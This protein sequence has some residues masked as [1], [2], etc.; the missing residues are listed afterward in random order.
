MD[1]AKRRRTEKGGN[2]KRYIVDERVG[3][4]AIRDTKFTDPDYP[5]LHND[6]EGVLFYW[7]GKK[8]ENEAWHVN[9]VIV[10]KI[11]LLC[12]AMNEEDTRYEK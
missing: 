3:C 11:Q 4:I 1:P 5:G 10:E 7:H 9:P 12:E 6:T 8:D 2:V